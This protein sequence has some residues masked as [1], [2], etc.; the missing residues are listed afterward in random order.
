MP[1]CID[2][3]VRQCSGLPILLILSSTPPPRPPKFLNA[4]A[5]TAPRSPGPLPPTP[6]EAKLGDAQ[7]TRALFERATSLPLPAKKMHFLFR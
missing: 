5:L 3:R 7:R 6:Q 1:T 4:S 2:E